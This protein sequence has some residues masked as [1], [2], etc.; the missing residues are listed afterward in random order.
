[1]IALWARVNRSHRIYRMTK[2]LRTP[3]MHT[4]TVRAI[5][6][7]NNRLIENVPRFAQTGEV[8]SGPI[9]LQL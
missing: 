7:L 4:L 2:L 3:E 6:E 8:I 9:V 1:M 5:G